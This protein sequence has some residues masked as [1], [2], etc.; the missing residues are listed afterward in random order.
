M[1]LQTHQSHV[2]PEKNH[3]GPCDSLDANPHGLM[4]AWLPRGSHAPFR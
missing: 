2:N 3:T 1:Y 4:L